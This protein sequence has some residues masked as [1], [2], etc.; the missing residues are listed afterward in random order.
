MTVKSS[1]LLRAD[2]ADDF[3]MGFVNGTSGIAGYLFNS[4]P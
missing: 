1:Y 4:L 2:R 3:G